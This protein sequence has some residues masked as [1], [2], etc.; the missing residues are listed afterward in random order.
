[1][2][3]WCICDRVSDPGLP[4]TDSRGR[5]GVNTMLTGEDVMDVRV[6]WP[7]GVSLQETARR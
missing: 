7:H 2:A 3:P 5:G 1:M 6:L 4:H